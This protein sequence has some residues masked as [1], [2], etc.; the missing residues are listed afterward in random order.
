MRG[1]LEDVVA[2]GFLHRVEVVTGGTVHQADPVGIELQGVVVDIAPSEHIQTLI[3]FRINATSGGNAFKQSRL[4]NCIDQ[5]FHSVVVRKELVKRNQRYDREDF[6]FIVLVK[7]RFVGKPHTPVLSARLILRRNDDV[8][9]S[10]V[11]LE[12][13]HRTGVDEVE[14][15]AELS[16]ELLLEGIFGIVERSALRLRVNPG[17]GLQAAERGGRRNIFNEVIFFIAKTDQSLFRVIGVDVFG[18]LLVEGARELR[19]LANRRHHTGGVIGQR[20]NLCKGLKDFHRCYLESV[21]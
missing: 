21:F 6:E 20:T 12:L 17:N 3:R 4:I 5:T 9:W 2:D 10:E 15:I 14:R 16:D 18:Q 7:E 19:Q 11:R 1:V 13:N 8:F